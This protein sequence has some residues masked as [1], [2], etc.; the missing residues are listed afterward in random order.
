MWRVP[1]IIAP[2]WHSRAQI[3]IKENW[4]S[5]YANDCV[6]IKV[7]DLITWQAMNVWRNIEA[8]S[9]HHCCSRKVKILHI[10][11]GCLYH[12][13]SSMECACAVLYCFLWPVW[14]YSIFPHYLINVTIYEKEKLLKIKCV[15]I[16]FTTFKDISHAKKNWT[17]MITNI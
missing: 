7:P 13:L 12:K 11:R 1:F 8:S 4:C 17:S 5:Y 9:C 16:F 10:L 3:K 6:H 15:S 14:L 2:L